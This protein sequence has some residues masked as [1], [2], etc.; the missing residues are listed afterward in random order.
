MMP[1]MLMKSFAWIC[2]GVMV[3]SMALICCDVFMRYLFNSPIQGATEVCTMMMAWIA[4]S[5]LAYGLMTGQHMQ[6]GAVYDKLKGRTA[7][8]MSFLIYL[9]G[10]LLYA[11]MSYASFKLFYASYLINEKAVAAV[12]VY[13]WI[14]KLGAAVG[15]VLL[16]IQ[17]IFMVAYCLIGIVHPKTTVQILRKSDL[18]TEEELGQFTSET[19][20][21]GETE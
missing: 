21:N 15:W 7:H 19:D 6:L 14:G 4:Y 5:G 3:F 2:A 16:G 1:E 10:F 13:V 8:I 17:S 20:T 9:L 12:T 11:V 18:P